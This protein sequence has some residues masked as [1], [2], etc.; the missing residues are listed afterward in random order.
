MH[1][2]MYLL[3]PPPLIVAIGAAAAREDR[4]EPQIAVRGLLPAGEL[5]SSD[6]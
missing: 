1:E 4:G 2:F 5:Y 3:I 6:G